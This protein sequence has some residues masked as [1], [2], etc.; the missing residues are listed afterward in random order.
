MSFRFHT[1]SPARIVAAL[2]VTVVAGC[3]DPTGPGSGTGQV[4]FVSSRAG[5]MRGATPLADIYRMNPD[6]SGVENLT[7]TPGWYD[8]LAVTPDGRTVIFEGTLSFDP[9]TGSNCPTQVWR[10]GADGS[11]LRKVTTDGCSG[12]PRLSPDGRMVAYLRGNEV[13]AINLDGTGARSVSHA[14]PPVQPNA[15]GEV[16]RTTVRTLGWVSSSRILFERHI[17]MQG[18]TYY[19]V[20]TQGNGI[21][22]T[23]YHG[24]TAYPSP[25]GSALVHVRA[26]GTELANMVL[27]DLEGAN[28]R[29]IAAPANLPERYSNAESVWSPDGLR[30]YYYSTAGHFVVNR[31]GTGARRIAEPWPTFRGGFNSWSRDGTRLAFVAPGDLR[32][33][34]LVMNADGTGLLNLTASSTGYNSD[35][36]WARH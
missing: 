21:T 2:A 28:M 16:P 33:D 1:A 25:D 3:G 15:C 4:I 10:I 17:C 8:D 36:V 7:R 24:A 20:D 22:A 29:T 26:Q 34:I 35:A 5:L 18:T 9:W 31:D 19:T 12:M 6:G 11:G 14:L 32:S 30:V 13:W 27:T 23:A